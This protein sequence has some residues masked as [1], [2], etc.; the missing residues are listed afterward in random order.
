[1]LLWAHYD[2]VVRGPPEGGKV[3]QIPDIL[4]QFLWFNMPLRR[5]INSDLAYALALESRPFKSKRPP[6]VLSYDIFCSYSKNLETR[7]SIHSPDLVPIIKNLRGIIPELH[8]NNHIE[9][10]LIRFSLR[11]RYSSSTGSSRSIIF[12]NVVILKRLEK[13]SKFDM[14]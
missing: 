11:G 3:S 12:F 10:C 9:T 2:M 13:C 1:M 6:E 14:L 8:I 4:V 5:F 7:F